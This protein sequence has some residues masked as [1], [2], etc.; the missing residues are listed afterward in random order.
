MFWLK[1]SRSPTLKSR[2]RETSSPCA[3]WWRSP[4]CSAQPLTT[5]QP[6]RQEC[7]D[8]DQHAAAAHEKHSAPDIFVRGVASL[9]EHRSFT[10]HSSVGAGAT[11]PDTEGP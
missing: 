4:G 8:A 7:Q 10:Q 5:A 2:F 3:P 1:S 11:E 9:A 6:L